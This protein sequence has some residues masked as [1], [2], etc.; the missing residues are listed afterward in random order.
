MIEIVEMKSMITM[1]EVIRSQSKIL[2]L[3]IPAIEE[4][5]LVPLSN[6]TV[7]TVMRVKRFSS[8]LSH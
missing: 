8:N 3:S 6:D 2:H 4:K 1:K 5:L 7:M